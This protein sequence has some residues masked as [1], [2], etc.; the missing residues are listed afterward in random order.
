MNTTTESDTTDDLNPNSALY[1]M[2][3]IAATLHDLPV[4]FPRTEFVEYDFRESLGL[5]DAEVPEA[6]PW[7]EF[8]TACERVEWPAFVRTDQKSVKHAGP[9]AYRATEPNDLPTILAVLTDHHA[10]AMRRPDAL[11]VREWVDIE[12]RFRAFDGLP[13]GREFRVFATPDECLCEHFYWPERAIEETHRG[14]PTTLD[15]ERELAGEEWRERLAGL[16]TTG[17]ASSELAETAVKIATALNRDLPTDDTVAW[18]VDFA[19]DTA[20]QWWCIDAAL[21]ADSWHPEDCEHG[22][23]SDA[24]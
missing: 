2:P 16:R 21:A 24:E 20:G 8:I 1:W 17:G 6:L 7:G 11:M 3:R 4:R 10:K 14:P 9:G 19:Q 18:S 22:G 13:I 5:M 15:G 12:S 23:E